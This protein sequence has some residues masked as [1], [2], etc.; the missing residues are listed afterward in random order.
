MKYIA[1]FFA[2]IA[3]PVHAHSAMLPHAHEVSFNP[4][5]AGLSVIALGGVMAFLRARGAK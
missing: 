3:A 4:L 1:P 5:F 2:L